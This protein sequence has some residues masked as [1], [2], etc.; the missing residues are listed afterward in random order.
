MTL[1]VGAR[2]F[3]DLYDSITLDK[4]QCAHDWLT[5]V[6]ALSHDPFAD[7][8]ERGDALTIALDHLE[9]DRTSTSAGHRRC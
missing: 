4:L 2:T 6:L 8:G 5:I 1:I 7:L 9:P 3:T